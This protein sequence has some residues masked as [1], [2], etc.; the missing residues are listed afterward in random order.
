M[1]TL[2]GNPDVFEL[3]RAKTQSKFKANFQITLVNYLRIRQLV[4]IVDL[5]I[6]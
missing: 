6:A 4:T 2:K 1:A 3:I 5:Q